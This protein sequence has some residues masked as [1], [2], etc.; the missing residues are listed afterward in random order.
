MDT[1]RRCAF[2]RNALCEPGLR[3]VIGTF[4]AMTMIPESQLSNLIRHALL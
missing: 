2:R 4:A 1:S 3:A